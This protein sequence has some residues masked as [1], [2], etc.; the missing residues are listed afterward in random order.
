MKRDEWI[1]IFD[2]LKAVAAG[3]RDVLELSISLRTEALGLGLL[4]RDRNG[5]TKLSQKAVRLFKNNGGK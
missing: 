5:N 4:T 2:E 1:Q 3:K